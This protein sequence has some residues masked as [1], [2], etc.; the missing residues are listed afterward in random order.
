[1]KQK[2]YTLIEIVIY[3]AILAALSALVINTIIIMFSAFAKARLS[4]RIAIDGETALER[5]T[6]ETRL[7]SSVND[8]QSVLDINLSVLALNSVKSAIDPAPVLKRFF[9][10]DNRLVL[11]ENSDPPVYLTSPKS[12]VSQFLIS[13][14]AT[15]KSEAIKISLTVE[16]KSGSAESG[17]SFYNTVILRGSY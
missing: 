10:S 8:G 3:V 17:R 13:K 5:L 1:M 7:A 11:Q 9:V 6:R 16:A 4:Q 14:I 15:A 12:A 2:G